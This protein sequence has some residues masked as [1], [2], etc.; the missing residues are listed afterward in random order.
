MPS[1]GF[2]ACMFIK[3]TM[4]LLSFLEIISLGN[5]SMLVNEGLVLYLVD[6]LGQI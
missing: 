4:Q 5:S 1:A 6:K 3:N 2:A